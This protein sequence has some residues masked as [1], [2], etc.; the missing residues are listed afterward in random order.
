MAIPNIKY[1]VDLTGESTTNR[2]PDERRILPQNGYWG[3]VPTNGSF[4]THN[5]RVVHLATGKRL[6]PHLDY[7]CVG[8]NIRATEL[9]HREVCS[10]ILLKNQSYQGE[11]AI[12][13]NVV[14]GDYS[15][16]GDLIQELLEQ[17]INDGRPVLWGSILDKPDGFVPAGHLHD[18]LD[19]YRWEHMVY[20]VNR[21]GAILEQGDQWDHADIRNALENLRASLQGVSESLMEALIQ[22]MSDK[23]NPHQVTKL[24]LE[25]DKLHNFELVHEP[26]N[27]P[28]TYASGQAVYKAMEAAKGLNDVVVKT[29]T[30]LQINRSHIVLANVVLEVPDPNDPE[31]PEGARIELRK[32]TTVSPTFNCP[33]GMLV[34]INGED[35]EASY[36][37]NTDVSLIHNPTTKKW[38]VSAAGYLA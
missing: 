34:T 29:N 15:I 12:D 26:T 14:G 5:L 16:N 35:H 7:L 21:L 17:A 2:V 8:L 1:P 24:Q 37:V 3:F 28:E 23:R 32:L 18:I 19:T 38:E 33:L 4:Y 31:I 11:L 20:A 25:L 27:D 9:S 22:H 13:Y 6:L 36:D 30:T 10:A